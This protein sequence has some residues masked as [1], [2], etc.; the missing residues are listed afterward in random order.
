MAHER[1]GTPAREADL[2]D[3]DAVLES[4]SSIRPAADNPD[5]AVIFGTSGH[6]GSSLNGTFN[7]LH[8]AAITQA[9]VDYRKGAGITGPMYVGKDSHAL[10]EPA[11]RTVL[12]VLSGNDVAVFADS[13]L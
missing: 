12:E 10:S 9:V 3:L 6:R 7:E 4:Y 11:Y 5:Q 8:I 1:A 2:I 13:G